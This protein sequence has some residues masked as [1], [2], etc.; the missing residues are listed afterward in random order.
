MPE[1]APLSRGTSFLQAPICFL[2]NRYVLNKAFFFTALTIFLSQPLTAQ[3][4]VALSFRDSL[5]AEERSPFL[6]NTLH[7]ENRVG[8]AVQCNLAIQ[9]P[10]G[11]MILGQQV[12]LQLAANEIRTIPLTLVRQARARSG[13][14]PVT[15]VVTANT[16]SDV[17]NFKINTPAISNY[18]VAPAALQVECARDQE[19]IAVPVSIRN[20]GTTTGLYTMVFKNQFLGLNQQVN[21]ALQPGRDS[22]FYCS[23]K[24]PERPWQGGVQKILVE[25]YDTAG[26]SYS[27]TIDLLKIQSVI[28][29]H[30]APYTTFP[31]EVETGFLQQEKEFSYYGAFNGEFA[32]KNDKLSFFYRSKTYGIINKLERNV[33]GINYRSSHW[34]ITAGQMQ[35]GRYFF[36]NGRGGK[37]V[38]SPNEKTQVGI[39]GAWHFDTSYFTNDN[40]SAFA[41]YHINKIGIK[42]TAAINTDNARQLNSYLL[43]NEFS[44]LNRN[45]LKLSLSAGAG[46]DQYTN[47]AV[48]AKEKLALALGYSL[49]WQKDKWT[50]SSYLQKNDINYPGIGKGLETH[51]HSLKWQHN[52]YFIDGYYQSNV[53]VSRLFRDTLYNSD[54]LTYNV[55]KYGVR[56]GWQNPQSSGIIG[57]GWLQQRGPSFGLLPEYLFTEISYSREMKK[58]RRLQVNSI[59]G[60]TGSYS[61]KKDK[62]FFTTTSGSLA[63][64]YGGI[65]GFYIQ[66]PIFDY[67]GDKSF[68]RYSKTLLI[69]PY[70]QFTLLKNIRVNLQ[71]NIS[72]SLYDNSIK[73]G[74]GFNISYADRKRSMDINLIGMIPF[75][76]SKAPDNPG[77]S[78]KY[79][80]L[81]IRKRL[82]LPVITKRKYHDL[83]VIPFNDRNNDG[84]KD[85]NEEALKNVQID[86]NDIPF[87]TD[88]AG[89]M[90]YRNADTGRYVLGFHHIKGIKGLVPARGSEQVVRLQSSTRM[91]IPFRK[92]KV[93]YGKVTVTLDSLNRSSFSCANIRVTATDTAGR[94]Y[95]M[96]TSKSGEYFLNLPAGIYVVSLNPEAFTASLKPVVMAFRADLGREDEA[97]INFEIRDKKREVRF[98]KNR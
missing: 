68:L 61:Y 66:T 54:L 13:W 97:I 47:P 80:N 7:F 72:Q 93:I 37:I 52:N 86:V 6:Y 1:D 43:N 55:E 18:A 89:R 41:K 11:W 81:F 78:T 98:L 40:F 39:S 57:S 35:E 76:Y 9:P 53:S 92:S 60:Y 83:A 45:K 14:L 58:G 30:P 33:Y 67:T 42:H 59:N 32:I 62:I 49:T 84:K 85:G 38:Y 65:K 82:M 70:A 75:S 77:L 63:L 50:L 15:I 22:V 24:L 21:A 10:P 56:G 16:D 79:I 36:V 27:F 20:L 48:T 94:V 34:D 4:P 51:F 26:I 46:M 5:M 28:K 64:K 69:G 71:Y 96:L 2:M 12:S 74:A 87:I 44:V 23:V 19:T 90:L 95:S 73:T 8:R 17:Y 25:T 31:F 3:L 88:S 91:E 29:N